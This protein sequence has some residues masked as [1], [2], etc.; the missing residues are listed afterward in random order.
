MKKIKERE[1]KSEYL[2]KLNIFKNDLNMDIIKE[3]PLEDIEIEKNAVCSD[4]DIKLSEDNSSNENNINLEIQN[5]VEDLSK[6]IEKRYINAIINNKIDEFKEI[7]KHFKDSINVNNPIGKS[8]KYSPIHYASMFGYSEIM[9]N[10]ITIYNADVNLISKDGWSPFHLCA[11]S[12][13]INTLKI[14]IQ[15]K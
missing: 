13:T 10:L 9:N 3:S 5:D 2:R 4:S 7:M 11:Y 1:N 14:L 15:T 12:G 8:Q 6:I